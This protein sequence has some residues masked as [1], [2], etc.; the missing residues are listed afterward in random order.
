MPSSTNPLAARLSESTTLPL[1]VGSE[2]KHIQIERECVV[3]MASASS[4]ESE[5]KEDH[6]KAREP[7]IEERLEKLNLVGEEEEDLDFSGGD[8]V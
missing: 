1:I 7:S 3:I 5:G 6:A 2:E 4:M 8:G